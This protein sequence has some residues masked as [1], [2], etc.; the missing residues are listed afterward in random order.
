[1]APRVRRILVWAGIALVA[2]Q[3]P[4]VW[5]WQRNPPVVREPVWN[6]PGT[7]ELAKAACFDCHSNE[8]V[9]PLYARIAP[10]SWLVTRDVVAGRERLNFSAIG[11]ATKGKRVT[12]AEVA[13]A[14]REGDMPPLMYR[15]MHPAAR[16]SA[17]SRQ[18][19]LRGLELS[20]PQGNAN[21]EGDEP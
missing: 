19:L 16:L 9:W 11:A 5:R 7:R 20:L 3:L 1:V 10:V 18:A 4:P 17:A 8:T 12:A 21:R 2:I 6:A 14:I 13:E 15:W